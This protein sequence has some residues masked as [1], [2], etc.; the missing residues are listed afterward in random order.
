[1]VYSNTGFVCMYEIDSMIFLQMRGSTNAIQSLEC[2]SIL[3]GKTK[4]KLLS[5]LLLV[6]VAGVAVMLGLIIR[7]R[8]DYE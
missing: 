7:I 8:I 2:L 3:N 6:D 1:M 4:M 5:G